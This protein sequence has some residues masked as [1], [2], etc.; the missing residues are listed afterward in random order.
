MEEGRNQQTWSIVEPMLNIRS[1]LLIQKN[2]LT[3][4]YLRWINVYKK[5]FSVVH[6]FIVKIKA[7]KAIDYLS[8]RQKKFTEENQIDKL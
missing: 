1:G 6:R 4:C 5:K 2:I 3:W 7:S 8:V